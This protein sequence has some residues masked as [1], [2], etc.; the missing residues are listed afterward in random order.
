MFGVVL[1]IFKEDLHVKVISFVP[2]IL[3]TVLKIS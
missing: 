3:G 2:Y 1:V